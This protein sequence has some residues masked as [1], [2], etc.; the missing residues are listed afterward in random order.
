MFKTGV[1]A[2]VLPNQGTIAVKQKNLGQAIQATWQNRFKGPFP[3]PIDWKGPFFFFYQR[4]DKAKTLGIVDGNSK[5]LKVDLFFPVCIL[6]GVR[7]QL[8][9][10]RHAGREPKG[11]HGGFAGFEYLFGIEQGAIRFVQSNFKRKRAAW[12]RLGI[13]LC[14]QGKRKRTKQAKNKDATHGKYLIKTNKFSYKY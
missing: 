10:A 8:S 7:S 6:F 2:L 11:K 14:V 9:H 5:Q 13:G 1:I 12:L 3:V 4:G